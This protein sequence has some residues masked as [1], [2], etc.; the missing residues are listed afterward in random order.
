MQGNRA[1]PQTSG[2]EQAAL[3]SQA[4]E[5]SCSLR[6]KASGVVSP[7]LG[8]GFKDVGLDLWWRKITVGY[9]EVDL[10]REGSSSD[11]L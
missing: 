7:Q 8:C 1:W 2:G 11:R 3:H 10:A 4:A 9:N 5:D 6:L